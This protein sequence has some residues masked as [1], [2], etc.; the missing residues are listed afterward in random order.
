ML[1]NR[2]IA[3]IIKSQPTLEGAGVHLKRVF[4]TVQNTNFNSTISVRFIA[5]LLFL[6]QF[7]G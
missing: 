2:R 4:I 3:Q 6:L 1:E 5:G 7:A